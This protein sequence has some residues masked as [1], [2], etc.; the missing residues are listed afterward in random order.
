MPD[1]RARRG[2]A[3]CDMCDPLA[4]HHTPGGEPCGCP[5]PDDGPYP[6]DEFIGLVDE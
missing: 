2:Y 5:D 4:D 1:E 3:T 6:G